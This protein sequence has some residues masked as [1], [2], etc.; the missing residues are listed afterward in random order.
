M[1]VVAIDANGDETALDT[2]INL[3]AT[4][5][6]DPENAALSYTWDCGDSNN[7]TGVSPSHVYLA[8]GTYEASLVVSDG[9]NQIT[10]MKSVMVMA[11]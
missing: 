5:S 3:N 11:S 9:V 10:Q 1:R 4:A 7:G 6:S 2:S 8:S